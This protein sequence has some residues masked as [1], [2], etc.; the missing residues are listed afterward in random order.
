MATIAPRTPLE[1]EGNS[2]FTP[3]TYTLTVLMQE[4]LKRRSSQVDIV[5]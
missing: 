4:S 1:P 5:K 2:S 3:S